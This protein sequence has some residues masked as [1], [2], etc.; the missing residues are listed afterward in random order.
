MEQNLAY[1]IPG[2]KNINSTISLLNL[3]L[4]ESEWK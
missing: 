3:E 4:R 2:L 1:Y